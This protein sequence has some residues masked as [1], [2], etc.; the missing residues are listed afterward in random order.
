ML[1]RLPILATLDQCF[2]FNRATQLEDEE[3]Q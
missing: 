1:T 3:R 2:L